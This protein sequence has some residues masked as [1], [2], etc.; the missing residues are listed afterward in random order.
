MQAQIHTD[1]Q[2]SYLL[3]SVNSSRASAV[4]QSRCIGSYTPLICARNMCIRTTADWYIHVSTSLALSMGAS[5]GIS[6]MDEDD[7]VAEEDGVDAAA[8][9][10]ADVEDEDCDDDDI[11]GKVG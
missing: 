11:A 2:A 1:K 7:D 10:D 6:M 5:V 4:S 9:D 3:N 8:D